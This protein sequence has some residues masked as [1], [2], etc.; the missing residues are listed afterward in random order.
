MK[1][2]Q[3]EQPENFVHLRKS[4]EFRGFQDQ[5]SA[6][7]DRPRRKRQQFRR[8]RRLF[9]ACSAFEF[10]RSTFYWS[11][12]AWTRNW[13]M[14]GLPFPHRKTAREIRASR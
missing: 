4:S 9:E 6:A 11:M 1:V 2:R 12:M 5:V 13:D 3:F 14:K 7:R 8:R 10:M